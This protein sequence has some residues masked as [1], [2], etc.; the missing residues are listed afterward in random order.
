MSE[1]EVDIP[2]DISYQCN[3]LTSVISA[4][5]PI[6]CPLVSAIALPLFLG[7]KGALETFLVFQELID[8]SKK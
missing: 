6:V 1:L 5:L 2:T 4:V 3:P 8:A 7:E